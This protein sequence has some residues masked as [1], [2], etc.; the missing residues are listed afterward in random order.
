[1]LQVDAGRNRLV[2]GRREEL[3][4][5]KLRLKD[6][7][8]VDGRHPERLECET[9]LRYRG[10]PLTATYEAGTL[11]LSEPSGS[12]APGQAAVFYRGSRVLGGGIVA[13]AF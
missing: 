6:V 10:Q 9:R 2:A 7:S 11:T 3:L 8:F 4:V 13:C 12:P 5:S 1:V